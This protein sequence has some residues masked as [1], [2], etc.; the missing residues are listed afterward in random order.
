MLQYDEGFGYPKERR[1]RKRR[2]FL[3][4]YAQG[5]RYF[6]RNFLLFVR[7][8]GEAGQ[9]VR[10]GTAVSKK[11]GKAVKRNR[12]KRLLKEF[13]RLHQQ[14]LPIDADIVAVPKRHIQAG[15]I[16]YLQVDKDLS[17]VLPRIVKD[18]SK[19][20]SENV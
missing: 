12:V 14:A 1:L 3:L 7:R 15:S 4:C 6:S 8:H 18:F 2:D 10:F 16:H 5:T 13:F 19:S 9:G 20:K 17:P 11:I